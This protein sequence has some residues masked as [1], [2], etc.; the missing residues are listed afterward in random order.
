VINF[1]PPSPVKE[2]PKAALDNK[3]FPVPPVKKTKRSDSPPASSGTDYDATDSAS[4]SSTSPMVKP[5]PMPGIIPNLP[6]R[7]S[8]M[9][10]AKKVEPII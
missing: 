10:P 6:M 2:K 4:Y 5:K 8:P 1:K 9:P 7:G 3:F